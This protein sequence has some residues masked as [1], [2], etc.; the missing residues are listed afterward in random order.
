PT[1]SPDSGRIP[2]AMTPSPVHGGGSGW[3][4]AGGAGAFRP[5]GA[6]PPPNP[7]PPT[8]GGGGA[9]GRRWDGK[10]LERGK[11]LEKVEAGAAFA[12]HSFPNRSPKKS[13]GFQR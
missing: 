12:L 4:Q 1:W 11:A 8:G 9:G 3:G 10:G 7:P 5:C 13:P 6:S 2:A